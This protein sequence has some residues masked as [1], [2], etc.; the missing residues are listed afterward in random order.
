MLVRE[1]ISDNG[2]QFVSSEFEECL[3]KYGVKHIK[4]ALYH[5]QNNPIERFNRVLKESLKA[6][7]SEGGSFHNTVLNVIAN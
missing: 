5:P 7:M 1:L 3:H 6:G 4:T 2:V